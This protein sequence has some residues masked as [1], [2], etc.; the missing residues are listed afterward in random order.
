MF[1]TYC[2]QTILISTHE[3][4][5]VEGLFD[6]AVFMKDGRA[7]WSGETEDLRAEY[8]SLHSVFRKFYRKE[9]RP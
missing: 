2:I 3:I 8:G 4:Y 5:E 7:I 6:Y 1:A 9:W